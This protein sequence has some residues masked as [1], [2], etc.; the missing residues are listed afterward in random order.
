MRVRGLRLKG[1]KPKASKGSGG[2]L[3][4]KNLGN[5][6]PR[7]SFGDLLTVSF[8]LLFTVCMH[9]LKKLK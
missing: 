3:P 9:V 2:M 7:E 1:Q 8:R 4:Q 5:M 6:T